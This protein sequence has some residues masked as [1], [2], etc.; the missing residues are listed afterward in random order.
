MDDDSF[1]IC[2]NC[3]CGKGE[4]KPERDFIKKIPDCTRCDESLT[5]LGTKNFHE[6]TRWGAL[7]G[8]G[9]LL[10]NKENLD[11]YACKSCGKVEF[12][13]EGFNKC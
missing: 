7:G 11:M 1:E 9:E 12:F 13:I 3:S 5:F 8:L 4:L 6:G 10:V 2:W